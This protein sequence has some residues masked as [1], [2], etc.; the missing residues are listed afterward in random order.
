MPYISVNTT[1]HLEKEQKDK[2][3][4]GIGG[5]MPLIPGKTEAV[6]MIDISDG[7]TMFFAGE[8]K[9]RCAF[10][11]VRCYNQA[12]FEA[13][14]EFTEALFALLKDTMGL[15]EN[16]IYVNIIEMPVWGSKGTLK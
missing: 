1:L 9:E 12:Q 2:I 11:D 8:N 14:K 5:I 13:N 4:K 6:L 7:H 15:A 16:E 10:V 3:A